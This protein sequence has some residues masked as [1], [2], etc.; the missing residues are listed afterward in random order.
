MSTIPIFLGENRFIEA[1]DRVIKD[2]V[3]D[4]DVKIQVFEVTIRVLGSLLSSYQQ[5]TEIE[6]R[7]HAQ[8]AASPHR[9]SRRSQLRFLGMTLSYGMPSIIAD[10]RA[11]LKRRNSSENVDHA[12]EP[13]LPSERARALLALAH[14]LG[15]RLLP[16]FETATGVPYSRVN[17]RHGVEEGEGEA[18]CETSQIA[19][20]RRG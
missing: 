13:Y 1:I 15:E 12:I 17:L 18:T 6:A 5:L 10:E 14:D 3:F 20:R 4:Q 8:T 2:T 11:Q 16:A 19:V 7:Q 9:H